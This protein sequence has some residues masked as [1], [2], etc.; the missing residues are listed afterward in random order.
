MKAELTRRA[1]MLSDK[2]FQRDHT[3]DTLSEKS[4][5]GDSMTAATLMAG[6]RDMKKS[7]VLTG[8]HG[9]KVAKA[10]QKAEKARQKRLAR[11][12]QVKQD[13][14]VLSQTVY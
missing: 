5:L 14:F 2:S 11:E 4:G 3:R 9:E 13:D 10:L 6:T 12:K 1:T 8:R 7:T